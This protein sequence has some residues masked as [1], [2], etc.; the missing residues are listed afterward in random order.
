MKNQKL[1]D[2]LQSFY[3][4]SGMEISI[5]DSNY[6]TLAGCRYTGESFCSLIHKSSVCLDIC[7]T[8]DKENLAAA[9]ARGEGFRCLCPFGLCEA[10]I[11]L[12][13]DEV[14]VGYAMCNMGIVDSEGA[15]E[16]IIQSVKRVYPELSRES[17]TAS[18]SRI[19]RLTE[20]QSDAYFDMLEMLTGHVEANRL[21]P[22][23][24]P[25]LGQ[26]TKEYVRNNLS[27][28]LTLSDISWNL[29][30]STVTL[31]QHFKAEFGYSIMSYAHKKRMELARRLLLDTDKPLY[32]V[33]ASCGYPD[34]EYFSRSFKRE[35][36][37]A[38]GSWRKQRGKK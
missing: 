11:P 21:L 30:C 35:H 38:P 17:I 7:K 18:L 5:V 13:S 2:L 32:E 14:T 33:A 37:E 3:L 27:E 24:K 31:T 22:V 19:P 25:S 26:L 28:K 1:N 23:K 6:H 10:F 29:H 4:I 9:E 34:V 20:A 12:R 8:S 15:D 16:R 36:G